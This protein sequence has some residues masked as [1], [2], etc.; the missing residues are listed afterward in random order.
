MASN[1]SIFDVVTRIETK[2]TTI[3]L[4]RETTAENDS[5][6]SQFESQKVSCLK[7]SYITLTDSPKIMI[8]IAEPM[9]M[10]LGFEIEVEGHRKTARDVNR[11]IPIPPPFRSHMAIEPINIT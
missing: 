3:R 11:G 5:V 8:E 6:S 2:A 4:Q 9:V 1:T 10:A 7:N